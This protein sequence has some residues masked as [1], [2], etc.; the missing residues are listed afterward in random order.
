MMNVSTKI[1]ARLLPS[2]L[3][4]MPLPITLPDAALSVQGE[5]EIGGTL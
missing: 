5:H 3:L 4:L 1:G 2:L